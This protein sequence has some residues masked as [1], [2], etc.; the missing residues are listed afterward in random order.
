[1]KYI[2]LLLFLAFSLFLFVFPTR[3]Y[4][5]RRFRKAWLGLAYSD[6]Y[7]LF[8]AR[9]LSLVLLLFHVAYY[10]LFPKDTG[11]ILS[12][13]YVFFSLASR[14]NLKVLM[15]LRRSRLSMIV[16]SV[17]A[18]FWAFFPNLLSVSVTMAFVLEAAC[19]LPSKPQTEI[20]VTK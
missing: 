13:L 9:M 6:N 19:C 11:I 20:H 15:A 2:Y 10:A 7:R 4:K 1:M 14:T 8:V 5:C 3:L 18:I 16:L 12:S 17:V